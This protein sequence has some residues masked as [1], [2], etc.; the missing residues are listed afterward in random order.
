M[1]DIIITAVVIN[2]CS[3]QTPGR[4]AFFPAV[5]IEI[6][7]R[8]RNLL[9]FFSLINTMCGGSA[10]QKTE[11]WDFHAQCVRLALPG[12]FEMEDDVPPAPP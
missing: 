5:S 8:R 10:G 7:S 9:L 2:D 1:N 3:A 11:K 12:T 4:R 6:A